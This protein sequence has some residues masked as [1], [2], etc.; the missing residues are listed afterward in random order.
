MSS[1]KFEEYKD[2]YESCFEELKNLVQNKLPRLSAGKCRV[3]FI[4][5]ILKL[6]LRCRR[7][8][9]RLWNKAIDDSCDQL[10]CDTCLYTVYNTTVLACIYCPE[11]CDSQEVKV[12]LLVDITIR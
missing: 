12:L 8:C 9:G 10:L 1:E 7:F 11:S 6:T 5:L 2:E 4:Y 3:A